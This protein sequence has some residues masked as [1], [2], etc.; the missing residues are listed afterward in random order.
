MLS[1]DVLLCIFDSYRRTFFFS[2]YP[3]TWPWHVYVHVCRRWQLVVF[4]FPGYLDLSLKCKSKTHMQAVLDVWPALPHSICAILNDKDTDEDDVIGTLGHRDCMLGVFLQG[5]KRSQ[6][7]KCV[8]LMQDPFPVLKWLG[9][10][11]DEKMAFVIPDAF[12]GGSAPLLQWISL[13]GV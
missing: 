10:G 5:S 2:N 1:D 13:R 3:T 6:L 9:L 12:L 8:A 4:T 11:A 7:E